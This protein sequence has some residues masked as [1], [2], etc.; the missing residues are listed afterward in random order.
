MGTHSLPQAAPSLT[1]RRNFPGFASSQPTDS[2]VQIRK[3]ERHLFVDTELGSSV[4][5]VQTHHIVG[6]G[7][8]PLGEAC[9]CTSQLLGWPPTSPPIHT[10]VTPSPWVW[11][12]VTCSHD[13]TLQRRWLRCHFPGEAA[14]TVT[15]SS[16][17]PPL[18]DALLPHSS[19]ALKK[20]VTVL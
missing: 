7:T 4:R 1:G 19:L 15:L 6:Y 13:Q 5:M 11:G 8:T 17:Y 2:P 3:A 12:P 16:S 9:V 18:A 10:R 20:P 14:K